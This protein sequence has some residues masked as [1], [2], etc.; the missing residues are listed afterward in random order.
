[1]R[2]A[3]EQTARRSRGRDALGMGVAVINKLAGNRALDRF[4][5]RKPTERVV[6]EATR[7]GFRTLGAISRGFPVGGGARRSPSRLPAAHSTGRF[8]LTP[9]EDQQMMV[10]V[11]SEFAEEVLRPGAAEANEAC[12]TPDDV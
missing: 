8:D 4:G 12:S 3:T 7:T 2:M 1:M 5:L 6:F 9:T 10:G 11:V